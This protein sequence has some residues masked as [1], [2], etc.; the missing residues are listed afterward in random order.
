MNKTSEEKCT[1]L[2]MMNIVNHEKTSI[3]KRKKDQVLIDHERDFILSA[4]LVSWSLS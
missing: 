3:R 2:F 1:N 4:I